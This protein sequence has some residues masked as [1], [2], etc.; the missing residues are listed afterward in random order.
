MIGLLL[1]QTN[2][3]IKSLYQYYISHIHR[4]IFFMSFI[5]VFDVMGPNMIGPSSSHTAGAARISY[6]AQK[7]IEGPLKRVDFILYGSFARTYHGHGTDR[8]LLGGIMGFPQMICA[9]GILMS[10]RTKM[11]WN[12]LLL[13][14]KQKQIS[15][16]IL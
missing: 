14:M 7:M 6:L 5:S 1:L 9:S 10:L 15:I 3:T 16:Q 4:R 2:V 12:F 8:A 11:V 13:Q